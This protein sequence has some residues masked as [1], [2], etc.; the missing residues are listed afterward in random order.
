MTIHVQVLGDQAVL[1]R[2][3]FEKLLLLARAAS[4]VEVQFGDLHETSPQ[5]MRFIESGGA[6]D[7]W[8]EQGEECYSASDGEPV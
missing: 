6:F 3:E 5:F 8:H 1:P 4:E 7:F 2:S